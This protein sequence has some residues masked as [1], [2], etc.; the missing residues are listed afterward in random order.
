MLGAISTTHSDF[1]TPLELQEALGLP[2]DHPVS[3][4]QRRQPELVQYSEGLQ[5]IPVPRALEVGEAAALFET[6]SKDGAM[7]TSTFLR[8]PL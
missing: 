3:P 4:Y 5:N 6:L 1:Q 2:I 8:F 7:H